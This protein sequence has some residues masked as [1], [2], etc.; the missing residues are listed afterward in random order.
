MHTTDTSLEENLEYILRTNPDVI[1]TSDKNNAEQIA[2]IM[3]TYR[4]KIIEIKNYD[5]NYDDMIAAH[6]NQ[7]IILIADEKVGQLL[8]KTLYG[9][10]IDIQK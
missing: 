10:T 4:E 8:R 1:Y 7:T 3:N 5:G 2:A 6:P 9:T